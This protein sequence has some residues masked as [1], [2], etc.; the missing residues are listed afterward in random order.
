MPVVLGV[1]GSVLVSVSWSLAYRKGFRY[2][3]ERRV[4]SW[5]EGGQERSYTYTDW[6]A[7]QA[8]RR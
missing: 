1:I 7:E 6:Q 8:R 5:V 3:Y 2:D 4:S